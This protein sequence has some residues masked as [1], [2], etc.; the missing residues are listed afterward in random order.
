MRAHSQVLGRL[1][2]IRGA[3]RGRGRG[4][5]SI[6]GQTH[7][8]KLQKSWVL[9][10]QHRGSNTYH[11][12]TRGRCESNVQHNSAPLCERRLPTDPRVQNGQRVYVKICGAQVSS[13]TERV[14][15]FISPTRTVWWVGRPSE[16]GQNR[17]Y[18]LIRMNSQLRHLDLHELVKYYTDRGAALQVEV[19]GRVHAGKP[20]QLIFQPTAK[21][22]TKPIDAAI[23]DL[24][25]AGLSTFNVC[26]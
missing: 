15:I 10:R 8:R 24:H 14:C 21:I 26:D 25:D 22:S 20:M 23:Q 5:E 18:A 2:G 12:W 13:A 6:C 9:C 19:A 4:L 3:R 7:G 17:R 11:G 1:L 16:H